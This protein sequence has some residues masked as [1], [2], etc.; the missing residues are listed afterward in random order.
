MNNFEFQIVCVNCGRLAINIEDRVKA[1]REATVY[2]GDCGASR[3]TVGALRDLAV[4]TNPKV[5]LP[6]RSQQPSQ[7]DRTTCDPRSGGEISERYSELQRLRRQVRM[8]ELLAFKS[9]RR[10]TETRRAIEAVGKKNAGPAIR[11]LGSPS[12]H[13]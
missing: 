3:G 12:N 9:Q 11:M 6:A 4:Q 2:C 1:P 13:F 5:G 7:K 8:A 10:Q